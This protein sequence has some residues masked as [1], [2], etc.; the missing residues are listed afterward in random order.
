MNQED[1]RDEP[2]KARTSRAVALLGFG[3]IASR[4]IVVASSWMLGAL[5]DDEMFGVGALAGVVSVFAYMLVGFGLDDVLVQRGR[6]L[7]LWQAT[8]FRVSFVLSV[9][10]AL[11][12][13]ALAP[14]LGMLFDEPQIVGPVLVTA[15]T[16]PISALSVVSAAQLS[17]RMDFGFILGWGLFETFAF[18]ALTLVFAALGFGAYSFALPGPIVLLLRAIIYHRRAPSVRSRMQSGRRLLMILRRGAAVAGSKFV[19]TLIGQGDYL[20]LGLLATTSELGFYYFA[21]RLAAAP[22]RMIATSLSTVLFPAMTRLRGDP[23]RMSGSAVKSAVL[24]AWLATPLSFFQI[25]VAAP[26]LHLFFGDKWDPSIAVIQLLGLGL[27]VEGIMAVTRSYLGAAGKF[28]LA[29]AVSVVN[30]IGFISACVAGTLL[31]SIHGL[32]LAVSLF[33]LITQPLLFAL[34]VDFTGH[35]L[36]NIWIIFVLPAVASAVAFGAAWAV[37]TLSWFPQTPLFAIGVISLVGWPLFLLL[38]RLSAPEVLEQLLAIAK[39]MIS[40]RAKR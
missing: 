20:V 21:F 31:G 10:V 13:A 11:A 37:S 2:L 3:A 32:A 29:F 12:T 5:L 1:E 36:R 19:N 26:A 34:L 40:R 7:A 23:A 28:N 17:A 38:L 6:N 14:V 16:F 39:T 24:L 22:I 33:Y 25:A 8:A 9:V 18:Q 35:R 4:I 27:A 30:A 15:I